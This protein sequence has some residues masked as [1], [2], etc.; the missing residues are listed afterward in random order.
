MIDI[1]SNIS[2]MIEEQNSLNLHIYL[3]T[4]SIKGTSNIASVDDTASVEGLLDIRTDAGAY[5]DTEAGLSSMTGLRVAVI[6]INQKLSVSISEVK[7]III[8]KEKEDTFVSID[9]CL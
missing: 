9:S 6:W 5:F 8:M 7:L 4:A 3:N 1:E 2:M